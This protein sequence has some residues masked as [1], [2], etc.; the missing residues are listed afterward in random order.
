MDTAISESQKLDSYKII[1]AEVQLF[2]D[3]IFWNFSEK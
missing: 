1:F 2:K 3:T